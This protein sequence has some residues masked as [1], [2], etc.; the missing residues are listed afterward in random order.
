MV[1]STLCIHFI[2]NKDLTL[3]FVSISS[4]NCISFKPFSFGLLEYLICASLILSN[5]SLR[6]G[7]NICLVSLSICIPLHQENFRFSRL[8]DKLDILYSF[9]W[10]LN[11]SESLFTAIYFIKDKT[12]SAFVWF[13]V[14][15]NLPQGAK[16]KQGNSNQDVY[17]NIWRQLGSFP[18]LSPI[19]RQFKGLH[20]A[21]DIFFLLWMVFV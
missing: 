9:L 21:K 15:K 5:S 11:G 8:S 17:T 2:S 12:H 16:G 20:F 1:C 10:Q 7:E 4:N 3:Q 18:S 19:R 14:K 13:L 6:S